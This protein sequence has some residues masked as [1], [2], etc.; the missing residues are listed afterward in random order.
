MIMMYTTIY[1]AKPN[2]G[3]S[4][5]FII[6]TIICLIIVRSLIKSFKTEELPARIF[7]VLCITTMLI[8]FMSTIYGY[9]DSKI[10]VYGKYVN[11]SYSTIV[12]K[13]K[14][15][16]PNTDGSQLPDRFDV[17]DNNFFVPGFTTIWGYPLRQRDGGVLKNGLN[18][19]VCYIKYK[20]ENVIMKLEIL[21]DS[22]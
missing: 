13:I 8:V 12:G 20:F 6:F 18:V 4:P 22:K 5:I 3:I 19:R 11:G 2:Y 7:F 17:E 10:L 14:N 21:K 15:Y 1:E 9:F 16:E